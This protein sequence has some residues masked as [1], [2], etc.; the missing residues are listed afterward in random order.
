MR[1]LVTVG[2]TPFDELIREIDNI[3]PRFPDIEFRTQV[4]GGAYRPCNVRW[5]RFREGLLENVE[6]EY[7][8][9]ITHCGAGTVFDLLE[10]AVPFLA[11][12][13]TDRNDQ[14]QLDLAEYLRIEGYA[15]VCVDLQ[16]LASMVETMQAHPAFRSYEKDE[17]FKASEIQEY[18]GI[19][20]TS[21][22][23]G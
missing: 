12:P 14:H 16:R 13:N 7:A 21:M 10:R 4:A 18:L 19:S 8:F 6:R 2:T 5:Q 3:A 20:G 9:V 17:F 22:M 11:V 1:V 23:S 15:L